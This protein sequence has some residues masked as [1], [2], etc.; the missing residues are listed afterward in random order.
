MLY[1]GF[2]SATNARADRMRWPRGPRRYDLAI[3]AELH[4]AADSG[5]FEISHWTGASCETEATLVAIGNAPAYGGG[6][7]I[8]PH[9]RPTRRRSASR[10]S[11]PVSRLTLARLAPTLPRAGHIGHPAVTTYEA[12][13]RHP[14]R[15]RSRRLRRRRARS[16]SC[17][18]RPPVFA[19][20]LRVLAPALGLTTRLDLVSDDVAFENL[21]TDVGHGVL[22]TLK[23]DGRPQLSNVSHHYDPATRTLRVSITDARAKTRNLRRDPR[24]SYHVTSADFWQWAVAEGTATLSAVA[25]ASGRR[26]RRGARRALPRHQRRASRLGRVPAGDGRRHAAG[27]A[28]AGRALLRP[29][30]PD[31]ARVRDPTGLAGRAT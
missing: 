20:A 30:R 24:A 21:L 1:C 4:P 29:G 16:A 18:S 6:K 17:R 22:V 25:A 11:R 28:P 14:R 7:L 8:A 23:A 27:H 9:A 31:P 2:D 26:G 15:A 19:G 5:R 10:S 12:T 3:A 13:H